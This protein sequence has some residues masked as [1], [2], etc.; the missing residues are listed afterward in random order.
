MK[1]VILAGGFGTRLSEETDI[2][3]KPMVEIG[4]KPIL[5]HIMKIYSHYGFNDFIICLGYKGYV[6]KEYFAN[7]FLHMSDVTI[8]LKNNQIDV[9]N[10]KA[11]SWKVTLVD[12]GLSTMT[13]GR[14]KRIKDYVGNKP[15]MLTYG[16]GVGNINIKELLEFHR[17]HGKYA[18]LTA[19]QPSGRFGSLDLEESQVKAFKEKPKGDGAWIN[20][21]FFVLEPQIFNYIK[22]DETIWEREPLENLAKEG[23]LMAYKHVGFWKPMDTLRDKREL[24]S[25]W[26]SGN[27]PW[28]VWEK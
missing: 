3:P 5:W 12:T 24:E 18:T 14:I 16:D 2:K 21:G 7:Y 19:V 8:D 1:V 4:G 27:P 26:Q 17:R 6:I 15:F 23:Q 22:G 20:G 11:E 13:G 28:K 9:H 25:L 10:V